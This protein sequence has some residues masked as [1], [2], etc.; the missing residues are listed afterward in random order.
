MKTIGV[1]KD[2]RKMLESYREDGETLDDA[3][4][5]LLKSTEPLRKVDRTITNIKLYDSTLQN[6][7][8]YKSYE[9]E[10]HNDTIV[11]LLQS[12]SNSE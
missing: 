8:A 10:S 1:T 7:I 2:T 5:R 6:L 11:K 4:N 9:T 3:I 12:L